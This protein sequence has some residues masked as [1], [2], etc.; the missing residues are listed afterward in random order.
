IVLHAIEENG[1]RHYLQSYYAHVETMLVASGEDVHRGQ[2]IATVG[3]AGGKYFAHLHFEMREFVT[4][5]IGA[6]YREETRGWLDPSEFI[7]QHRGAAE[8]DV[9]R[10]A[11]E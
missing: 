5:Y 1:S 3:S 9:G 7:R 11:A 2:Q 6:G 10:S 4:P 8:D